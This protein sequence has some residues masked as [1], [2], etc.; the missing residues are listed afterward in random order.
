V[1]GR[2]RQEERRPRPFTEPGGAI[3]DGCSGRLLGRR[4]LSMISLAGRRRCTRYYD[5]AKSS[6]RKRGP[7]GT[8]LIVAASGAPAHQARR[9]IGSRLL[10]LSRDV[11]D[12]CNAGPY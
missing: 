2:N 10:A 11:L 8:A 6:I 4:R 12:P 1:S 3:A 7:E 5:Y 9:G